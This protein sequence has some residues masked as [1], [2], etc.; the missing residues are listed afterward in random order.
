M[1]VQALTDEQ[2]AE[3]AAWRYDFPYEWYDTSADPRRVELFANPAR[4]THLRAVRLGLG[5]RPDLT[6]HGLAQPFIAAGLEYAQREWQPR[7]FR[8]WVASWNERALRAYRRAGFHQVRHSEE[9]RFVEM[10]RSA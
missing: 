6:S 5:M 1:K 4:R 7:T 2:A 8:L 9:S 3:I 10:E